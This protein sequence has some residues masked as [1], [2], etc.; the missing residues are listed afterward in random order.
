MGG[1]F[2]R[3]GA[4]GPAPRSSKTM[5]PSGADSGPSAT[6]CHPSSSSSSAWDWCGSEWVRWKEEEETRRE[7]CRS[8]RRRE[9]AR[10]PIN[11]AP[12][13][14]GARAARPLLGTWGRPV[15]AGSEA[16]A[17]RGGGGGS[18]ARP[19][20]GRAGWCR[21]EACGEVAVRAG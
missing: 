12:W 20:P 15:A 18:A 6:S 17:W 2:V 9:R 16:S 5:H 7:R 8:Q 19:R 1:G 3:T 21:G 11:R 10:P 4:R 13:A 14:S